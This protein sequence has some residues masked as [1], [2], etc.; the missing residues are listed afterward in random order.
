MTKEQEEFECLKND[1]L[2]IAEAFANEV[3]QLTYEHYKDPR[4]YSNL[5]QLRSALITKGVHFGLFRF[6]ACLEKD[7]LEAFRKR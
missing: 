6:K 4:L 5:L 1:L 3:K 2:D 7:R